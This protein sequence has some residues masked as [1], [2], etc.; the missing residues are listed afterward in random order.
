MSQFAVNEIGLGE[1]VGGGAVG[2][3]D[4]VGVADAVG[5]GKLAGDALESFFTRHVISGH[6][7]GYLGFLRAGGDDE[8]VESAVASGFDKDSGF[9]HG[10]AMRILRFELTE[11]LL[12]QAKDSGVNDGVELLEEDRI[13]EHDSGEFFAVDGLVG[14]IEYGVTEEFAGGLVGFAGWGEDLV[15]EGICVDQV[16]A[17]GIQ[18]FSDKGL[19]AC[20]AAG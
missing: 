19:A 9:D 13:S 5:V 20:K 15:T 16:A 17:K 12:F 7:A 2:L 14:W 11:R 18:V 10:D 3:N 4:I 8:L 1:G 6:G